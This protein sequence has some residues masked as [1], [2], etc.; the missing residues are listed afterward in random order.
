[1]SDLFSVRGKRTVVTGGAAGIGW[2]IASHFVENEAP[3]VIADLNAAR[4]DAAAGIGADFVQMDVTDEASVSTGLNTAAERMGG[5][6]VLVLNAGIDLEVGT[7]GGFDTAA[8]RKVMDVNFRG[9]VYGLSAGPAHMSEGGVI[10]I[11][12][13]PAGRVTTAGLAAYSASKAAVDSITRTAAIEL[14]E[15]KIRVNAVLPGIV[16]TDMQGGSTGDASDLAMI[17]A[18]GIERDPA[19]LAPVYHF[20]ASDAAAPMTGATVQADDGMTAGLSSLLL[21]RALG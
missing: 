8:F 7:S 16:R 3:V 14:A 13:S 12:S 1:M 2:A 20:L 21:G 19:E 5:I 10:L 17:T 11:T 9:V 4:A 6:D 18:T 15:R